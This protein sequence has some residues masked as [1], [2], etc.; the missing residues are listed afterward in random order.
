MEHIRV[1]L[2][3]FVVIGLS[4]TIFLGAFVF[5]LVWANDRNIP[6]ISP[7]AHALLAVTGHF[8]KGA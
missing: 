1:N 4:A 2:T 8:P 6:V 3:N 5:G 7:A